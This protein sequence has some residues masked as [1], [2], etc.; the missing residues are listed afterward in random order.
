MVAKAVLKY[1]CS[2]F[3][4]RPSMKNNSKSRYTINAR[5]AILLLFSPGIVKKDSKPMGPKCPPCHPGKLRPQLLHT[6][7]KMES[8]VSCS[9][10]CQIGSAGVSGCLGP[11]QPGEGFVGALRPSSSFSPLRGLTTDPGLET[12]STCPGLANPWEALVTV[13]GKL[14]IDWQ[15]PGPAWHACSG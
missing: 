10:L 3:V 7:W 6:A 8:H 13:T 2:D 12:R 4:R 14:I 1:T 5:L 15:V 11:S 9:R